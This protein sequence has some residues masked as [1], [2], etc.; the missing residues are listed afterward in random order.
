MHR[1]A[2][3]FCLA[4][5]ITLAS[6]T[7][8]PFGAFDRDTDAPSLDTAFI[9]TN[10]SAPDMRIGG[11]DILTD[12]DDAFERK[13]E[14]VRSAD[15][16]I[17]LAYYLYG[18]DYSSSLLS[19]E[20]LAATARGVDVR[21][22]LDYHSHYANLDH[23]LMLERRGNE[24]QG[25]LRVRLFNRPTRNIIE[26][27]VFLTLG[28][29][30]AN[31][32]STEG[33]SAAK[34]EQIE[35]VFEEEH[36][37]ASTDRVDTVS[38][39][40][41]VNSGLFLSGLYAKNPNLM[42]M[43]ASQGQDIDVD[44][45]RA[46]GEDA[47]PAAREQ[48]KELGSLYW[49]ANYGGGFDRV[50][51]RLKLSA[52]FLLYGDEIN[53]V[54]DAFSA[55]LPVERAGGEGSSRRDWSHLTDFLHHK[56]LLVDRRDLVIGGRNVQ[57]SYHM[58]SNPLSAKY[59][60]MDTDVH[61]RLENSDDN[62][63]RSF[64]RLWGFK[65]MVA[66]LD[67]VRR[68][69]PNDLLAEG[70]IA[71]AACESVSENRQAHRSCIT[72]EMDRARNITV[73]ERLADKHDLM[74]ARAERYASDYA[75]RRIDERSRQWAIDAAATIHYV[76]NLPFAYDDDSIDAVG[77][78][79]ASIVG[80]QYGGRNDDEANS[81]KHLS[82]LWLAAMKA[83]CNA[84]R[85]GD[86]STIYLHNAY[87]FLP[88]NLLS[89]VARMVDGRE[90]C[91]NVDIVVLTNS[92]ETTDLNVVNALSRHSLQALFEHYDAR[93]DPVQGATLAYHEYLP[94]P[95]AA[96]LS[97]HSK[98]MVFGDDL[99][100]GSANAD[101][102]SYQMDTNNGIL[103]QDQPQLTAD[104][105]TWL[106]ARLDD[107]AR[108][109]RRDRYFLLTAREDMLNEGDQLVDATLARYRAERFIDD[110]ERIGELKRH[111][112][113]ISNEAYRLSRRIVAGTRGHRDAQARLDGLFKAI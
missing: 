6:C 56:L 77:M 44:T 83:V 13:L 65:S 1:A 80:R 45:L 52:A 46:G 32:G 20:I 72:R 74:I 109:I 66:S 11:G 111:L 34:F 81:G 63:V 99:F 49:Q 62:L 100:I 86:R 9:E 25:S 95:D 28:C 55:Y 19:R 17:E 7:L 78:R 69:A 8:L 93:H 43:A 4:A 14:L 92:I 90:P 85:E 22:L 103:I 21:M 35:S 24:G 107:P 79:E 50:V 87:F 48:L 71:D 88:S 97:L 16:S 58:N 98:I 42:A 89:R 73:D 12:N 36:A 67:D 23:F 30:E 10:S 110:P 2:S 26:D 15:D 82:A 75:P 91:A 3:T 41:T 29:G 64:D 96:N 37:R 51:N 68:H 106:H 39:L 53:P 76:E 104:Y 105:V 31:A 61:L 70:A 38:N 59:T 102:R 54:F 5:V 94:D 108:T 60:F 40:H 33:C 101:F 18:D 113:E 27:A 47:D 57:D 112:R 84:S